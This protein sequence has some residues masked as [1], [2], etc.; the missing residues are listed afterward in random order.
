MAK[1]DAKNRELSPEF[2]K[3]FIMKVGG[4]D[5][6]LYKGLL[7]LAHEEPAYGHV[8]S[9]I[10]Q[11][12][13]PENKFTC[14]ARAEIFNKDGKRIGME[15][16]DANAANCGKMTAA[17]FPRMALTR[18]KARAFRDFLN[19]D[20]VCSDEI[21]SVYEPELAD[22]KTI[23]K[24]KKIGKENEI[25]KGKL[26]KM[27]YNQ[28]GSDSLNDLTQAE[29]DEFLEYLTGKYAEK[30]EKSSKKKADDDADFDMEDE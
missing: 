26:M 30:K 22:P 14:F 5:A 2:R 25:E 7:A 27:L 16:A 11:Y 6:V 1:I 12:P 24:I 28:T 9:Y 29:A 4:R 20:M 23:G 13:S 8:E 18:A 17:S 10:T 21:P 3:K 15:E 19:V